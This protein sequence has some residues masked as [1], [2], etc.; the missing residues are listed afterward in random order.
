MLQP[1]NTDERLDIKCR[2]HLYGLFTSKGVRCICGCGCGWHGWMLDAV[3][4]PETG[5]VVCGV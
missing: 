2:L 1:S 3:L 4:R 5:R